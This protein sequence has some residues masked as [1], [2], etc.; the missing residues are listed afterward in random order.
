MKINL[1]NYIWK[2]SGVIYSDLSIKST[3]FRFKYC[4]LAFV[5]K[6]T[7]LRFLDTQ[8]NECL[9]KE[10]IMQQD[11]LG[12]LVWPYIHKDWSFDKKCTVIKSHY[13]EVSK[14]PNLYINAG[15]SREIV[16]LNYISKD[17]KVIIDRGIWFR[18]EGELVLNLYIDKVRIYSVV[19]SLG[20]K[21]NEKIILI[22]G[23]QGV[24]IE[25]IMN[26]YKELTKAL[27]GM[28]PRDFLLNILKILSV[29]LEIHEILAISN[30]NRHHN[31]NY[32]KSK[33][34]ENTS[35][36][37][38]M[39]WE[40]HGGKKNTD[41]FYYMKS[42]LNLKPIDKIV[43]KKRSMYRKRYALLDEIATEISI[44]LK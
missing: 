37:Y 9:W 27:Y 1:F 3:I 10:L 5:N 29:Q 15:E 42:S 24:T 11:K 34:L 26:I 30:K 25:N 12:I 23:I 21:D 31:H 43:S 2:T 13:F 39:I 14:I 40:E 22:G 6:N 19:F 35:I 20:R 28:R 32:F 33:K 38:D 17:L 8:N 18:R 7:I 4:F 44:N 36:N 41:G 16:D